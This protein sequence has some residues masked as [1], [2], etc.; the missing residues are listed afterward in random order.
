MLLLFFISKGKREDLDNERLG[1]KHK[2]NSSVKMTSQ[3]AGPD[4][5][6]AQLNFP[7]SLDFVFPLN[8]KTFLAVN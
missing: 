3:K 5:I 8:V 6:M 2:S 4:L 7:F 1:E